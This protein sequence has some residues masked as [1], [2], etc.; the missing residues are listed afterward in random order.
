MTSPQDVF[1]QERSISPL[2]EEAL[3]Y[4][5]SIIGG[6]SIL[7][8]LFSLPVLLLYLELSFFFVLIPK[9]Y[10]FLHFLSSF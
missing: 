6:L 8:H 2:L 9:M 10:I 4:G 7:L 5:A 3:P 1:L